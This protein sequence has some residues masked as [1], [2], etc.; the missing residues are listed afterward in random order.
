MKSNL[1]IKLYFSFIQISFSKLTGPGI[2]PKIFLTQAKN[3]NK[4]SLTQAKNPKKIFLAQAKNP[5]KI[6]LTQAKNPNKIFLAQAKNPNKIFLA[7][8]KNPN[9]IFLTQ[10]KNH[11]DGN[12]NS[13]YIYS[14]SVLTSFTVYDVSYFSLFPTMP[15]HNLH[16]VAPLVKSLCKKHNIDYVCLP[17]FGAFGHII[18]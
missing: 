9:K 5:N 6:F 17:L 10:A 18:R 1:C 12:F 16:K 14:S 13:I 7:Q 15:R 2:K 11:F 3:P 8:A 4:I